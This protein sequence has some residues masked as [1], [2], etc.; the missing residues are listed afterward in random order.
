M[1]KLVLLLATASLMAS[2]LAA[3]QTEGA[4]GTAAEPEPR[5]G[6]EGEAIGY[7]SIPILL[8]LILVIG[9]ALGGD[10]EESASA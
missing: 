1:K 8:V 10:E 3:Q 4:T 7:L 2:P 5:S 9:V 6:L